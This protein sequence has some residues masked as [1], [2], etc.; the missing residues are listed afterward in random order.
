M[1]DFILIDN[2]DPRFETV[3]KG[4]NLRWPESGKDADAVYVCQTASDVLKAANTALANN[5]RITVRSGGHCYEGFVSN[6]L[7][8]EESTP[9]AIID[10]GLMVGMEYSAEGNI[11]S[12]YDPD[13]NYQFRAATGN[14]N[15]DGYVSLYKLTNCTVPGG[16]CY[17][18]GSGG[19]VTGGGYGLLSRLHGLTVDWLSGIDILVP[20]TDGKSLVAKHVNLNSTGTDR[21]LFIACRG[22]GGGNFGIILNYYYAALPPAPQQVYLLSL[23]YPWS[24]FSTK[25]Q[26]GQFLKAYWQWFSTHDS[27]WNSSDPTLANGGL[28]SLL[29]L[30]H[31]ST[32]DIHLLVQYTG[33]DGRVDGTG[34]AAPFND[35][36]ATMNNA[37][38]ITPSVVETGMR[39]GAIGTAVKKRPFRDA[40]SDARLMDWLYAT[41]TLNGSGDNQR[42]K[43]KSVYHV[44]NF[45]DTEITALWDNLNGAD[46]P[47][48]NQA[49]VQIDS[50]GGCI[51]TNNE[52][53][54]PTAVFQRRSLLKS[55]FQVYWTKPEND[56]HCISWMQKLYT[57]YFADQG[58]KPYADD[59]HYQ[60][61]YINYP[62]VDMK[63]T[64]ADH[65][66]EDPQWMTLYYGDK[67][68][69]LVATKQAVDP[70]N[71][72]RN[73]MSVPLTMP[74]DGS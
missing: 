47:L 68:A 36:V 74:G 33:S 24:S 65:A 43:Y 69:T 62:D 31:R 56:A 52:T 34:Q 73:E 38:G 44:A 19:H 18:V 60:G 40:A 21:E 66:T 50:Y 25:E 32:G 11:S 2:S 27:E 54:N 29:K 48:L 6:K 46:D 57:A 70:K 28:F 4:F 15:W 71:L 45:G 1:S 67:A 16:S 8:G 23:A 49:L 17:S 7:S 55:Q 30:Q 35:F 63:Y 37:A 41:Q 9:L 20:E 14:Q 64:A 10:L 51:N 13:V 61:C 59:G 12:P 3:K 42:G 53:T 39:Y 26:F 72:F 5:Q 22:G 58:G